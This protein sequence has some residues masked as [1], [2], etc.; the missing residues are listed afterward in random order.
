MTTRSDSVEAEQEACPR[1]LARTSGA[2]SV[3]M[4]AKRKPISKDGGRLGFT[5]R[6]LRRQT[7]G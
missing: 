3:Y 5:S 1:C 2:L 6:L 4:R 7:T